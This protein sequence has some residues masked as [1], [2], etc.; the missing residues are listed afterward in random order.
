MVSGTL[1]VAYIHS[2]G[3]ILGSTKLEL[4]LAYISKNGLCHP[5]SSQ[6]LINQQ[7]GTSPLDKLSVQGLVQLFLYQQSLIRLWPKCFL[8]EF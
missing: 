8:N 6:E 3:S 1:F 4:L 2:Q 7:G 5:P